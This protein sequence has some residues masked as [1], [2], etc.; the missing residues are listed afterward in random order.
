[1]ISGGGYT[2]QRA[3]QDA[4]SVFPVL[5]D[6]VFLA[7]DGEIQWKIRIDKKVCS[8]LVANVAPDTTFIISRHRSTY[9]H[10]GL[11]RSQEEI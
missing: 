6:T 11:E 5:G 10:I 7:G 8:D 1:M 4:M 3:D 2:V 9:T